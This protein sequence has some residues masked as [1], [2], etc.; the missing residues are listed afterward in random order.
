MVAHAAF[1][2]KHGAICELF[3]SVCDRCFLDLLRNFGKLTGG[4]NAKKYP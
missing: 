2:Y 1:R 3:L 4:F